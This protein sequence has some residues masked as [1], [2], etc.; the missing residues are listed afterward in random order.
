MKA[1]C[2]LVMWYILP[3]IRKQL[4]KNMIED[5]GLT[6]LETAQKLGISGA[7][8]CQYLAAKRGKVEITEEEILQQIK[9]SAEN[10]VRG[11]VPVTEE[12]C[13]I[14]GLLRSSGTMARMI[15]DKGL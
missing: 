14:C 13:R 10:I 4:A 6:Q 2:E 1:P 12:T 5:H 9:T 7:A 15:N 3:A 11:N 8:V